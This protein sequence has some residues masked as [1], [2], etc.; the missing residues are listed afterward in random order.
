MKKLFVPILT[1][2]LLFSC[3]NT[4][5]NSTT[6]SVPEQTERLTELSGESLNSNQYFNWIGRTY[7]EEEQMMIYNCASGFEINFYGT[8]L[9]AVMTSTNAKDVTSTYYSVFIDDQDLG[10]ENI[11]KLDQETQDVTLAT[12]LP[13]GAHTV[14]VVK[15]NEPKQ[16][17]NS[18][19]SITTDGYF[20]YQNKKEGLK[21]ECLGGS[22]MCGH[23]ALGNE[24]DPW[25]Q[26]NSSALHSF[27]YLTARMF[28]A[29]PSM[30]GCSGIGLKWG[31][32]ATNMLEAYDD[33]GI[34]TDTDITG[35]TYD[36]SQYQ[37]D[38]VLVNIGG[39]DY[40]SYVNHA[41]DKETAE[42]EFRASVI[43]LCTKIHDN[44]PKAE[45]F[46]IHTSTANGE[47]AEEA[48]SKYDKQ[49][50][51]HFVVMPKVGADGDPEG[52]DAHNSVVTHI[53]AA[54]IIQKAVTKYTGIQPVKEN[55]IWNN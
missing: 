5:S 39:N 38:I 2:S 23:G 20:L 46:W 6:E 31:F 50:L 15:R 17:T 48:I 55:I 25:T 41:E 54:D 14:K 45:I 44:A 3:S 11:L 24:G 27:A 30:I 29:D 18:L 28:D 12:A 10:E 53:R 1:I 49:K 33:Y 34:N 19:K 21:I 42:K 36:H 35:H 4:P 52:A 43:K 40:T 8:E 22:G 37:P 13:L 47:Q 16:S 26:E 32:E 7:Y 9:N 51:V